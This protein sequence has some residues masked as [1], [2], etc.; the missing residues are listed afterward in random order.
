MSPPLFNR[1]G[2]RVR[3]A[4]LGW[5]L[6][7]VKGAQQNHLSVQSMASQMHAFSVQVKG[8]ARNRF[9][10]QISELLQIPPQRK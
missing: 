6:V 10:M 5:P 9:S 7:H 3:A 1:I 2:R 4:M 8:A